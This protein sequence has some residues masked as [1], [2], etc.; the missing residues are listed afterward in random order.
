MVFAE[1][2]GLPGIQ[3][4]PGSAL[5]ALQRFIFFFL[6]L[7]SSS[8]IFFPLCHRLSPQL[9]EIFPFLKSKCQAS[10][11]SQAICLVTAGYPQALLP[12][13]HSPVPLSSRIPY[14]R[15]T[16]IRAHQK[17]FHRFV[18]SGKENLPKP[19][20]CAGMCRY[21]RNLQAIFCPALN[22]F[23]IFFFLFKSYTITNEIHQQWNGIFIFLYRHFAIYYLHSIFK[24]NYF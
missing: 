18:W 3:P 20:H 7:L 16:R 12:C 19:E 21:C 5:K 15:S 10:C 23:Q 17:S 8:F 11:I 22:N 14:S 1:L 24:K 2:W 9:S 4:V 13:S 6:P